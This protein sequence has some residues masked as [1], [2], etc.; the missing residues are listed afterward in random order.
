MDLRERH[1]GQAVRHPWEIARLR[2]VERLLAAHAGHLGVV[3]AL[4]VGSGDSF[5]A[6]ELVRRGALSGAVCWDL[7][8]TAEDLA[9]VEAPLR[10]V[11]SQPDRRFP[12]ALALDVL[13]HV[14]DDVAFARSL[15][16]TSLTAGGGLLVTVPAFQSL[17]SRHDNALGHYRR[18]RRSQIVE[19]LDRAGFRVVESGYFFSAL[20]PV[21]AVQR[22]LRG[23]VGV[24]V[25]ADQVGHLGS[26]DR[27]ARLT[28]AVTAVL[29]LENRATHSLR[30]R[31]GLRVPGLSA[32]AYAQA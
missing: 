10:R 4:D 21:R 16:E 14:P 31:L 13:E 26:W 32:W 20:L 18:Y 24:E 5:L 28:D 8:Y 15:R 6:G 9:G 29:D 12:L 25:P 17:F 30:E 2:H 7:H 1:V 22:A 23:P 19:T 3:E 11:T 27:S